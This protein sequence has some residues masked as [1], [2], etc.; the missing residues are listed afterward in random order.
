MKKVESNLTA[1]ILVESFNKINYFDYL[2]VEQSPHPILNY[3]S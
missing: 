2:E 1:K 3:L